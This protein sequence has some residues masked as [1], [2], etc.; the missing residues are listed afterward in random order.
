MLKY[1]W[2]DGTGLDLRSKQRTL[3]K[4]IHSVSGLPYWNY[5]GSSTYQAVTSNSEV[6]LK[7]AAVYWDPFRKGNSVLVVCE[8]YRYADTEFKELISTESNF[9]SIFAKIMEEAKEAKPWFGIEQEYTL[10]E[11]TGRN[12]KWPL[13]LSKGGFPGPQGAYY[14]SVGSANC[15]GRPVMD[16]HYRAC[17]HAGVQI[18]GTNGGNF[19]LRQSTGTLRFLAVPAIRRFTARTGKLLWREMSVPVP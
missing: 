1:I 10:F 13:G 7:P 15:F 3:T 14:C 6:I 5:D 8:T 17:L 16:A 4:Q 2:I 19:L 9:S 12:S 18:S 11:H